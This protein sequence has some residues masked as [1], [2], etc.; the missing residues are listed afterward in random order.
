M[1]KSDA[2]PQSSQWLCRSELSWQ[3]SSSVILIHSESLYLSDASWALQQLVTDDYHKPIPH[4]CHRCGRGA[5][6]YVML[7]DRTELTVAEALWEGPGEQIQIRNDP[8]TLRPLAC[9]HAFTLISLFLL[10]AL[11]CLCLF[12]GGWFI[13]TRQPNFPKSWDIMQNVSNNRM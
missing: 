5:D 11:F 9:C 10:S 13:Y 8:L 7:F 6:F 2:R 3:G 4:L 1:R 12:I